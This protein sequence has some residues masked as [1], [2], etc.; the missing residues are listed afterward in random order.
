MMITKIYKI[1]TIP[2]LFFVTSPS[3]HLSLLHWSIQSKSFRSLEGLFQKC[4]LFILVLS[5]EPVRI[6]NMNDDDDNVRSHALDILAP[7]TKMDEFRIDDP[8]LPTGIDTGG[9]FRF[10][11]D[12]GD[13]VMVR[14]L[15]EQGA[16]ANTKAESDHYR[17]LHYALI[18]RREDYVESLVEFKADTNARDENGRLPLLL[19][20]RLNLARSVELLLDYGAKPFQ[21]L[22][23]SKWSCLHVAAHHGNEPVVDIILKKVPA[24]LNITTAKDSMETP[25]HLATRSGHIGVVW[26][27]IE[28]GAK[29][30]ER[31]RPV[32][33]TPLHISARMGHTEICAM[34]LDAGADPTL[35]E[36]GATKRNALAIS[37]DF[38][39]NDCI[40]LLLEATRNSMLYNENEND[41]EEEGEEYWTPT[42]SRRNSR[43]SSRRTG[44]R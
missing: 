14:K 33:H 42:P 37:R 7:P 15:L 35:A 19:A 41:E 12:D 16:S 17:P 36:S 28:A 2:F 26:Q 9:E 22:S 23:F 21:P 32:G 8:V 34:L 11:M 44:T 29:V 4:I 40:S 27:L 5:E 10:V 31:N 24:L 30:D 13:A 18:K 43:R 38:K 6:I 1:R 20:S 25:L 39:W 3:T